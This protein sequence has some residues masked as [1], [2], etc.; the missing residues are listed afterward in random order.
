MTPVADA[1]DAY[2]VE[3]GV[4]TYDVSSNAETLTDWAKNPTLR[5]YKYYKHWSHNAASF[6][7]LIRIYK[8]DSPWAVISEARAQVLI[9]FRRQTEIPAAAADV[10]WILQEVRSAKHS[11][12]QT[13]SI[14]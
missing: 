5:L 12:T 3:V 2:R 6:D 11:M 14:F 9:L 1:D 7:E 10:S 8:R 13:F 4:R